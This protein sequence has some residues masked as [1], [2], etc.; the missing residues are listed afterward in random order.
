VLTDSGQEING[1]NI[2]GDFHET[3]YKSIE[4]NMVVEG[5]LLQGVQDYIQSEER[6]GYRDHDL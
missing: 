3:F 5:L 4:S 6:M 2:Q 1:F